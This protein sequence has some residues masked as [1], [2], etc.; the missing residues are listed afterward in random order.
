MALITIILGLFTERFLGSL[1][2]YRRYSW[3]EKFCAWAQ[4]VSRNNTLLDGWI[5]AAGTVFSVVLLV[6]FVE[7]QISEWFSAAG[8]LF[9]LVVFVFCLGP[10]SFYSHV[11][12]YCGAVD[13]GN[14]A[15]AQW[16]L[17][18]LLGRPLSETEIQNMP[19]SMIQVLFTIAHHRLFAVV[20]WFVL[21]GPAGAVFFRLCHQ[22][23]GIVQ[24]SSDFAQSMRSIYKWAAWPTA[25]I[26]AFS[27][28]VTGN[29]VEGIAR[30][31]NS[32]DMK[33]SVAADENERI[34]IASGLG[35]SGVSVSDASTNDV[36]VALA[37]VRRT[38]VFVIGLI[39]LATLAGW[40]G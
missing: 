22:A 36:M 19:S 5:G 34:L 20:F 4:N 10:K 1:E 9:G 38:G 39:A 25:R 11:K 6:A 16:H 3:F 2:E 37:L 33:T 14:V 24:G 26:T 23:A 40:A 30:F 35:A 28:A 21:F 32:G 17:E 13:S 7:H 31:K 15:S 18:L 12:E 27:Y 29:F 8:F